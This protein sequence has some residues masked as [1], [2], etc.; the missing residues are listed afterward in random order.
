MFEFKQI[1]PVIRPFIK[2]E[3]IPDPN[4]ISGFTSG[5]GNFSVKIFKG[6]TKTGYRVQLNFR[7]VQHSRDR[8]L[9]ENLNKYFNSGNIYNYSEKSAVVLEIFNFSDKKNVILPFFEK[10][11]ILGCKTFGLFRLV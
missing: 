11:P 3:I 8:N 5:E 2:T 1:A 7:L 10:H 6:N 9:M 4:W